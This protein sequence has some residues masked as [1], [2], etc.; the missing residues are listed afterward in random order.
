MKHLLLDIVCQSTFVNTPSTTTEYC[1]SN[2]IIGRLQGVNVNLR[3]P[4]IF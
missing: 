3:L 2:A 4:I 1:L